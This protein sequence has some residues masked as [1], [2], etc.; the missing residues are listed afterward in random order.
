[1]VC[2]KCEQ[3]L[4]KVVT[5]DPWKNGARNTTEGGGRKVNENKALS[6]K[7]R[8]NPYTTKF[9]SC[10]ICRQ[11]VHQVGSHYCQACAYKKGICAMCGKK[12]ISTKNYKQS[13]S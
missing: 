8:F 2:G 9:E 5:P 3:K 11:K 4:G 12:I 1:M 13:S 6:N 10:R 7:L